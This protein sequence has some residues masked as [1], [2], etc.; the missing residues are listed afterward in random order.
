MLLSVL[1]PSCVKEQ[2]ETVYNKQEEQKLIEKPK[3]K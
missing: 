3:K 2:L 1:A